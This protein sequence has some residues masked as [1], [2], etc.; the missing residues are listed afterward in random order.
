MDYAIKKT[1]NGKYTHIIHRFTQ[2]TYGLRTKE[3]AREKLNEM[4]R[5]VQQHP[6]IV[7]NASA[8]K[9]EFQYTLLLGTDTQEHIRFYIDKL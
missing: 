5:R 8:S 2:Q 7:R 6:Q 4:W 9:D 3:A 1:T